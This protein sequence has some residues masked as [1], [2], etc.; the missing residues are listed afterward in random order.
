MR[1][2]FIKTALLVL[3]TIALTSIP[4]TATG[5]PNQSSTNLIDDAIDAA[6]STFTDAK[7]RRAQEHAKNTEFKTAIAMLNSAIASDP[8]NIDAWV[9]LGDIHSQVGIL[10]LYKES[11]GDYSKALAIDPQRA[12]LYAKRGWVYLKASDFNS[13][14]KD[15]TDAER[16][17]MGNDW[18]VLYTHGSALLGLKQDFQLAANKLQAATDQRFN[19]FC[20]SLALVNLARVQFNQG[21]LEAALAT[22]TDAENMS[23]S[24]I[25]AFFEDRSFREYLRSKNWRPRSGE[26]RDPD[27]DMPVRDKWAMVIGIS[28]FKNAELNRTTP[29]SDAAAIRAYLTKEAGFSNDHVR[30]LLNDKATRINIKSGL[31]WLNGQVRKGDLVLFYIS[32]H[33]AL[34]KYKQPFLIT[35]ETNPSDLDNTGLT[36]EVFTKPF[37]TR[38]ITV[39]DACSSGFVSFEHHEKNYGYGGNPEQLNGNKFGSGCVV[40]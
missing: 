18:R 15:A 10:P 19:Y 6:N 23:H 17:G 28:E 34:N 16:L 21:K 40:L 11:A 2:P 38:Q 20:R 30:L 12:D 14:V 9:L 36:T 4:C 1:R 29:A 37:A 13:A 5:P 33:G 24:N 7:V 22:Y 27:P 25:A 26:Y 32:S 35:H 3:S 31:E 39:I 8:R